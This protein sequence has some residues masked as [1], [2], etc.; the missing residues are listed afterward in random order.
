MWFDI[1]KKHCIDKFDKSKKGELDKPVTKLV[2]IINS[3][4]DF[5]TTSSCSGRT[6]LIAKGSKK[7]YDM[8]WLYSTHSRV[9]YTS[10][11]S[12]L[13]KEKKHPV[14][15]LME[16]LILHVCCR[17]MDSALEMLKLARRVGFKRGGIISVSKK[18]T[19]EFTSS[20]RVETII[21]DNGQVL[22]P[23]SY[24]QRLV[25]EAN[26]KMLSNLEKIKKI[27]NLFLGLEK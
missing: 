5:F 11:K 4:K 2:R 20:E 9:S 10:L 21:A 26:K 22:V 19:L 6:V 18:I 3:K 8:V 15:F 24:L 16:P 25:A 14:W 17:T 13:T 7:K 23:D 1:Y 12:N 27:E